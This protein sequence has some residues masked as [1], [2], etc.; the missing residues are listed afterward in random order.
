M[1]VTC[2]PLIVGF[3]MLVTQ[4]FQK[5][6]SA[7]HSLN[8]LNKNTKNFPDYFIHKTKLFWSWIAHSNFAKYFLLRK[9]KNI[10]VNI[11]SLWRET[12]NHGENKLRKKVFFL[13]IFREHR[14]I[15]LLEVSS[16]YFF[17]DDLL[18]MKLKF[19]ESST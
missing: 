12:A 7:L 5:E 16:W 2:S 4:H 18:I 8:K 19:A 6:L 1:N 11:S 9:S 10:I 15:N 17:W 14:T 13:K 3:E